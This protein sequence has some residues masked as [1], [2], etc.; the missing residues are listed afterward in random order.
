[1]L[2]CCALLSLLSVSAN[3]SRTLEEYP[4][5]RWVTFATDVYVTLVF[6]TEMIAKMYSQGIIRV[7][8]SSICRLGMLW[9]SL[10]FFL[11]N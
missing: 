1:M 6:T 11:L 7:R 4:F 2:H 9:T 3:T 5:L 8:I 10:I